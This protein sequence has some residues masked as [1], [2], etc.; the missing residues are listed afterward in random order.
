[1]QAIEEADA[2]IKM[3]NEIINDVK[4]IYDIP[5]TVRKAFI[6]VQDIVQGDFDAHTIDR[7]SSEVAFT[8]KNSDETLINAEYLGEGDENDS[9]V[10][11]LV[12][13]GTLRS[14]FL[15]IIDPDQG[16][17]IKSDI[18][19]LELQDEIHR[20]KSKLSRQNLN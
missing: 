14:M 6:D 2:Y 8:L 17:M 3:V 15:D 5:Q 12:R 13:G 11:G 1:M 20:I 4:D 10:R 7:T 16:V 19:W 9:E 18:G